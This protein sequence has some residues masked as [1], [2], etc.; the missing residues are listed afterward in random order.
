MVFQVFA[1]IKLSPEEGAATFFRN[2][3]IRQKYHSPQDSV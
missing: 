1:A 3:G 2:G